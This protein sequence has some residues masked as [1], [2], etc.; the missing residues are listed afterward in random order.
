MRSRSSVSPPPCPPRD[1]PTASISSM[2]M[3]AWPSLRAS[4]KIRAP[5]R[6]DAGERLDEVG[7]RHREERHAGLA[8]D[9]AGEHVLPVPGG[10][11]SRKPRGALAPDS[12]EALGVLEEVPDLRELGHHLVDPADVGESSVRDRRG[13][14]PTTGE[15]EAPERI[16][17]E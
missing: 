10:P 1:L 5:G 7:T 9:R 4:S 2:K 6:A 17:R 11:V 15:R 13:N 12:D 16:R 8:G 14:A 3:I